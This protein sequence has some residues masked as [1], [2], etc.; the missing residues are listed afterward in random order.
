[1]ELKVQEEGETLT[2]VALS[3]RLDTTG[4]DQIE[5]PFHTAVAA[6]G[7]SAIVDF[8]GVSFLSSMGVR[9]LLTA[10]RNLARRGARLVLQAP[11]PLV[12]ESIRHAALEEL[13]PVAGDETAARSMVR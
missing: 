4:V 12:L 10:A 6:R 5:T 9:M 13:I 2:R 3:G 1:M 7:R 8:S 11:Q